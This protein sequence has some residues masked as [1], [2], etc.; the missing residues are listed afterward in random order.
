VSVWGSQR[1]RR[2][3][4]IEKLRAALGET[5]FATAFAAGTELSYSGALDAVS[6]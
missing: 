5:E 6:L 4:F 3:R 1:E 2:D